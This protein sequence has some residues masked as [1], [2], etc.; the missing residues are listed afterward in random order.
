[1]I[2]AAAGDEA[3]DVPEVEVFGNELLCQPV[4]QLGIRRRIAGADIVERLNQP[5]AVQI[6]PE[7][8]YKTA[9]EVGIVGTGDP[10]SE[11]FAARRLIRR[12]RG[13]RIGKPWRRN[14]TGAVV[15]YLTLFQ[16]QHL[17]VKRLRSLDSRAADVPVAVQIRQEGLEEHL[18]FRGLRRGAEGCCVEIV[19]SQVVV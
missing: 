8:V 18:V 3:H 7:P 19:L 12:L 9:G 2:G 6:A 14:L 10:G 13:G 5:H 11:L 17:F 15:L 1:M 4:E 16:I